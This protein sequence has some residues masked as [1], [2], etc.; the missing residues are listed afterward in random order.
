MSRYGKLKR[1][2]LTVPYKRPHVSRRYV[3]AVVKWLELVEQE[4]DE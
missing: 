4:D 2:L 1:K 3:D